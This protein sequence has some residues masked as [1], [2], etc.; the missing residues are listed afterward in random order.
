MRQKYEGEI[1]VTI[2]QCIIP[3]GFQDKTRCAIFGT[4][5][6][7]EESIQLWWPKPRQRLP[8]RKM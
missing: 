2:C 3:F 5:Q 6:D 4:W 7:P 1:L 8:K